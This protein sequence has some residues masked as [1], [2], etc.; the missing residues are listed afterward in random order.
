MI[1]TGCDSRKLIL[2]SAGSTTGLPRVAKTV[3]APAAPPA[4][5]PVA[6]PLPP[7]KM[8]PSAAPIPA[9]TATFVASPLVS[10]SPSFSH[11]EVLSPLARAGG[12]LQR[13]QGHGGRVGEYNHNQ[14]A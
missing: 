9:P 7:P 14:L 11:A 8:A 13:K 4:P 3:P 5:A 2:V 10:F 1:V 12:T 6:A